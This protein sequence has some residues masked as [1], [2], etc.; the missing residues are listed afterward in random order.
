VS[1]A[2]FADELFR[3]GVLLP[4]R[5]PP[6]LQRPARSAATSSAKHRG[7]D[8]FAAALEKV[9]KDAAPKRSRSA[10]RKKD[11][12]SRVPRPTASAAVAAWPARKGVK[13]LLCRVVM[14]SAAA[15]A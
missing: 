5:L 2:A 6:W 12:N 4:L 15:A 10:D 1:S 7:F 11:S 3:A 14:A 13:K 8:P 9:R